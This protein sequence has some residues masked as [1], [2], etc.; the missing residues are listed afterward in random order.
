M[1][2]DIDFERERV[3]SKAVVGRKRKKGERK[4][5]MPDGMDGGEGREAT[6][7]LLFQSISMTLPRFVVH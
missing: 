6:K 5:K 4:M 3:E 7:E 1:V 2:F